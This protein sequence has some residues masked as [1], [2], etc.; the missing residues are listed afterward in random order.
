MSRSGM[1]VAAGGIQGAHRRPAATAPPPQPLAHAA[2]GHQ[3]SCMEAWAAAAMTFD[4]KIKK[5]H[6]VATWTWN[7]GRQFW[8]GTGREQRPA[9]CVQ[10]TYMLMAGRF[11]SPL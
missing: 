2:P 8:A 9:F 6:A 10:G 11:A 1:L 4:V 3:R 5:W 7:A